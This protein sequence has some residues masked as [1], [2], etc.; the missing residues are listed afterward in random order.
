MSNDEYDLTAVEQKLM[1]AT[2][3]NDS[4]AMEQALQAFDEALRHQALQPLTTAEAADLDD[5]QLAERAF[6]RLLERFGYLTTD[7]SDLERRLRL[8]MVTRDFEHD[9]FNGGITQ[10]VMNRAEGDA[11][12]FL[13]DVIAGYTEMGEADMAAVSEEALEIVKAELPLRASLRSLSSS[14]AFNRY[15]RESRLRELDDRLQETEGSQGTYVRQ[16]LD[17]FLG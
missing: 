13:H 16:N 5:E 10:F 9:S 15:E 8:F 3:D 6:S 11:E 12:V 2:E 17:A 4:A 7:W 14:D 1:K